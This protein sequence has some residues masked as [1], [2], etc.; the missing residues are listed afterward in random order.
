MFSR[1]AFLLA[2]KNSKKSPN[3]YGV[4]EVL[5]NKETD[6][7]LFGKPSA[8]PYRRMGVVLKY[9]NK[10]VEELV[11]EAKYLASKIKVD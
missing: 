6:V 9:G 10:D 1:I 2:T 5:K 8:R 3:F 11:E 7:R 4:E